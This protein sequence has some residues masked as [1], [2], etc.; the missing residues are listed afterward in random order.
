[1]KAFPSDLVASLSSLAVHAVHAVQCL[2]VRFVY[3]IMRSD[4]VPCLTSF[5]PMSA[6]LVSGKSAYNSKDKRAVPVKL[7]ALSHNNKMIIIIIIIVIIIILLT[8]IT[9]SS[10]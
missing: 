1:M 9:L 3:M 8:L 6:T 7:Y 10:S 5:W 4:A 2:D